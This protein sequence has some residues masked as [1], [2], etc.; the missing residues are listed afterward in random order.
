MLFRDERV[1]SI[2]RVIVGLN[3][4]S[5]FIRRNPRTVNTTA[6]LILEDALSASRQLEA[7]G[8]G[9]V[10]IE[11]RLRWIV[12]PARYLDPILT[13]RSRVSRGF[14]PLAER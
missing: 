9:V 5:S 3:L 1:V 13:Q 6:A 4:R 10:G 7:L 14:E 2:C 8:L 12:A 11:E